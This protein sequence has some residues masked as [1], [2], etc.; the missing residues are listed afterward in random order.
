MLLNFS[1]ELVRIHIQDTTAGAVFGRK[2]RRR[3]FSV[4]SGVMF[5]AA[6]ACLV[7]ACS[8]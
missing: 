5:L 6:I 8:Y 2:H 3:R 4:G 7:V 1:P